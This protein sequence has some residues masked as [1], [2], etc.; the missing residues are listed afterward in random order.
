MS[1]FAI[2][3]VTQLSACHLCFFMAI[4]CLVSGTKDGYQEE[5]AIIECCAKTFKVNS[6]SL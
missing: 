1:T 4:V 2:G 3:I 5:V 6:S